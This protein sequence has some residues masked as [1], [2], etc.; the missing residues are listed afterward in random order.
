MRDLRRVHGRYGDN[1]VEIEH[2]FRTQFLGALFKSAGQ[3]ADER[4]NFGK[5]LVGTLLVHFVQQQDTGLLQQRWIVELQLFVERIHIGQAV[6]MRMF[7]TQLEAEY[8]HHEDQQAG[9]FDVLQELVTHAKVRVG[10]L[11]QTGKIGNCDGAQ[12]PVLDGSNLGSD[13]G[14]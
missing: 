9:A 10:A 5:D 1:A 12:V 13:G 8:I 7:G 4:L 2:L 6:A 14:N 3:I 11:D